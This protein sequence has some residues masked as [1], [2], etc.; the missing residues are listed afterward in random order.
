MVF[1]TDDKNIAVIITLVLLLLLLL[2]LSLLSSLQLSFRSVA[3]VLTLI[4]TKQIR[5]TTH[6]RNSTK[7]HST[8]Y[9]K[10]SK[11]KLTYYQN[12]HTIVKKH[13]HYKPHT[14]THTHVKK[15]KLKT[16][17][18]QDTQRMK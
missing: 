12:T 9:T 4:Q 7:K 18:V 10:R 16:T 8:K 13:T 11:C 3:V 6:K 5:I 1:I 2:L 15:N 14:H 17:T